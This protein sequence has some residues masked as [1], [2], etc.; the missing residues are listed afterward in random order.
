M[1]GSL[2]LGL[3]F[4]GLGLLYGSSCKQDSQR[5]RVGVGTQTNLNP[6]PPFSTPVETLFALLLRVY[7]AL[8]CLFCSG[9][10]S[11]TVGVNSTLQQQINSQC[12]G[13]GILASR[14]IEARDGTDIDPC[15]LSVAREFIANAKRD[16][17]APSLPFSNILSGASP[18]TV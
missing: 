3:L 16:F 9:D 17:E 18:F 1:Y 4:H 5:A 6:S 10:G 11:L 14:E 15:D 7:F 12:Y 13:D 8:E 2:C